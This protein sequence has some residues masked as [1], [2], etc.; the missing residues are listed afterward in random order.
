LVNK[1]SALKALLLLATNGQG[2][3]VGLSG[4]GATFQTSSAPLADLAM[5][6]G[7]FVF[8]SA[9]LLSSEFWNNRFYLRD[10]RKFTQ[11]CRKDTKESTL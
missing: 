8:P 4:S 7:Y 11:V 9:I 1:S 10:A 3:A 2:L 6:K 5:M